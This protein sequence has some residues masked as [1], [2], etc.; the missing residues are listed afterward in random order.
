MAEKGWRARVILASS[1]SVLYAAER[2]RP[3][4]SY[5]E[6]AFNIQRRMADWHFSRGGDWPELARAPRRPLGPQQTLFPYREV[7]G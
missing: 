2:G 7:S 1:P 3:R 6:P 5:I 4:Q